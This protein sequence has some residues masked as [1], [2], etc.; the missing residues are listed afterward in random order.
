MFKL[1]NFTYLD[2]IFM[3]FSMILFYCI[4]NVLSMVFI[5]Q[6]HDW[7]KKKKKRKKKKSNND[8]II[9]ATKGFFD[10]VI[11]KVKWIFE[12]TWCI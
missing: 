6:S 2:K 3:F 10:R 5:K 1:W 7:K 8:F 9:C 11:I 4:I 12:L